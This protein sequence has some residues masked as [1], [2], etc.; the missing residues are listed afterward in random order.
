M[1]QGRKAM[2]GL[3]SEI[4][5]ANAKGVFYAHP[6]YDVV[7]EVAEQYFFDKISAEEAAK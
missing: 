5:Q 6:V 4:K 1:T 2:I 3:C 7:R